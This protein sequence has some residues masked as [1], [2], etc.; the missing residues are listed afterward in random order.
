MAVEQTEAKTFSCQALSLEG[1]SLEPPEG[2]FLGQLAFQV[3]V[4]VSRKVA[5]PGCTTCL[6]L[7]VT[8]PVLPSPSPLYYHH[9]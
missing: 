5:L 8:S 2:K 3:V 1:M 4:V 6:F 7:Q 9:C